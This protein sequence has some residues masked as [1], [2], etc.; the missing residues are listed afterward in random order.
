M[1]LILTLRLD[2]QS[3]EYFEGLRQT[4]YPPERNHIPA[5]LTLFHQL[6]QSEETE[7][8]LQQI[9]PQYPSYRIEISGLR[10]LGKGVA[11]MVSSPELQ[12]LHRELS[13]AFADDLIAQDR[14]RFQPHIVVQNKVSPLEARD[15]L[16]KLQAH[17]ESGLSPKTVQAIGV[18]LW[19][20]L[21]GP[22]KH[23]G[24]CPFRS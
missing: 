11:F 16:A 9:V 1:S 20:Y 23:L 21:D 18:D 12:A 17:F 7:R 3:Q 5:H 10:S 19:L 13:A 2:S 6:P 14:Q 4:Y 22:W 8:T 24:A 15:L